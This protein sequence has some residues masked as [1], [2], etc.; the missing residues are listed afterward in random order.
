ML[1]LRVSVSGA[2]FVLLSGSCDIQ[3]GF[4]PV[5]RYGSVFALG[6]SVRL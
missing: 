4:R 5:V 6:L 3:L 2:S 1:G